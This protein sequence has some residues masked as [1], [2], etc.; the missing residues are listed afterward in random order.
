MVLPVQRLMHTK[1]VLS[2]GNKRWDRRE[3]T[4]A[5][6]TH[7]QASEHGHELVA[8]ACARVGLLGGG[9]EVEG[10]RTIRINEGRN[11]I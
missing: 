9:G 1:H 7:S 3:E 10:A 11:G 2:Q 4:N 5:D 6:S 8:N